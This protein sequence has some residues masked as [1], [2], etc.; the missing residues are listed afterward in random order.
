MKKTPLPHFSIVNTPNALIKS[1]G[2]GGIQSITHISAS[3][4]DSGKLMISLHNSR[5]TS[6]AS[7]IITPKSLSRLTKAALKIRTRQEPHNNQT[8]T[9]KTITL[10][11]PTSPTD[12]LDLT[13]PEIARLMAT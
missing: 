8:K 7:F 6:P 2:K 3:R 4:L 10:H 5:G 11:R 12:S 1:R 9:T 13:D